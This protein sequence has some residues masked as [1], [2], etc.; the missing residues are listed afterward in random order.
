MKTIRQARQEAGLRLSDVA[1]VT[2]V[3]V[4]DLSRIEAGKTGVTVA[5]LYRVAKASGATALV[6]ALTPYVRASDR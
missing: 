6:D 1:E 4:P 3:S 2:G 5:R